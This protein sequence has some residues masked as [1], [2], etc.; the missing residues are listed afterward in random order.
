MH[1]N[2]AIVT[3]LLDD[4]EFR[5]PASEVLAGEVCEAV[6]VPAGEPSA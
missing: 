1:E 2:D 3:R 5:Q 4:A 6:G